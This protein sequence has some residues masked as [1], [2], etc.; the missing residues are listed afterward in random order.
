MVDVKLSGWR[1][2]VQLDS[3]LTRDGLFWE[4]WDKVWGALES[5]CGEVGRVLGREADWMRDADA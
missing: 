5:T 3:V 1:V 4:L 2:L